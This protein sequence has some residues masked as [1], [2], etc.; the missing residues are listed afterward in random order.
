MINNDLFF[1]KILY[2]IQF[3]KRRFIRIDVFVMIKIYD[4]GVIFFL[5]ILNKMYKNY[6]SRLFEC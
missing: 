6:L 4:S 2:K 1:G 3:I 5:E